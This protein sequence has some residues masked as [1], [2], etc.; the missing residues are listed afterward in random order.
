[1][2]RE[3]ERSMKD[4]AAC[5]ELLSAYLDDQLDAGDRARL[6]AQ[7][8]AD[9][10][11]RAELEALRHTVALLREMPQQPIPCNFILPQTT[12]PSLRL[13]PA[14][15][16]QRRWLAPFLTAATAVVSLLFVAVLAGDLFFSGAGVMMQSAAPA[17]ERAAMEPSPGG[18][19][20]GENG[21]EK[22]FAITESPAEEA[23]PKYEAEGTA[24][25]DT[26][27]TPADSS[28][29]P[30]PLPGT[31]GEAQE[32]GDEGDRGPELT[33]EA[34]DS[35][36]PPTGGGGESPTESPV[37]TPTPTTGR[38]ADT[39]ASTDTPEAKESIPEPIPLPS[40]VE[41]TELVVSGTEP[42]PDDGAETGPP[43]PAEGEGWGATVPSGMPW[44]AIEI[45]LGV[46][47][48]LL[49]LAMAWAWRA[50]RR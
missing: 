28:L 12:A 36:I 21:A 24:V 8:A 5:D 29:Q 9:P 43:P 32:G 26:A 34:E 39:V 19:T 40:T 15:R 4:Q 44:R 2:A 10:A 11:L 48:L 37:P 38:A 22:V 50:R 18:E 31:P 17:E 47:A 14:A 46:A 6:E 27:E 3:F 20:G 41:P 33:P 1:M 49:A 7:L 35:P 25:P 13:A 42:A 45:A 23:P 16:L 30:T